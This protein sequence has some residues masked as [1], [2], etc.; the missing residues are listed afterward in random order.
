MWGTF[1]P[2]EVAFFVGSDLPSVSIGAIRSTTG[3]TGILS[4]PS[5]LE[6]DCIRIAVGL[7]APLQHDGH[8]WALWE[9]LARWSCLLLREGGAGEALAVRRSAT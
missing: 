9:N 5:P 8:W 2:L 7:S 1:P 3:E 4:T 6:F